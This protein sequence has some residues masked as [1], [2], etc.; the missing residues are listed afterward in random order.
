M[1][2]GWLSDPAVRAS[3]LKRS[4]IPSPLSRWGLITLMATL[5]SSATSW[6]R[7]TVAIPPLPSS[8]ITSNSPR[9]AWRSASRMAE[10]PGVR[11]GASSSEVATLPCSPETSEPQPAQNRAPARIGWPQRGQLVVWVVTGGVIYRPASAYAGMR[12]TAATRSPTRS[13]PLYDLIVLHLRLQVEQE[14]LVFR[15]VVGRLHI[16]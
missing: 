14:V 16:R 9:V 13:G 7:Y 10:S 4:A 3:R 2:C 8:P 6:A 11:R 12:V 5:R 1:M 15:V